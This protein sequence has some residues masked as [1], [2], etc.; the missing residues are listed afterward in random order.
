MAA[1]KWPIDG[2]NGPGLQPRWVV[3]GDEEKAGRVAGLQLLH[4]SQPPH[5]GPEQIKV[6][7]EY[8]CTL[9]H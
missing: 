3:R 7:V 2:R 4:L 8:V 1:H 5:G 9:S 6:S